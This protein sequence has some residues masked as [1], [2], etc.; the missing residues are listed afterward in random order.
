MNKTIRQRI[1]AASVLGSM[2]FAAHAFEVRSPWLSERGPLAYVFETEKEDKYSL[3]IWKAMYNKSASKAF[4]EHGTE[5]HPLTALYFGKADFPMTQIFEN[6]LVPLEMEN[7]IPALRL[8][9]L[10][11]RAQYNERGITI[12]GRFEYPVYEN[13]GRIGV[14]A[15]I[16]FRCIEIEREDFSGTPGSGDLSDIVVS[17]YTDLVVGD[18]F[19]E[20]IRLD[21]L[22]ALRA[23]TDYNSFV[24]YNG[25]TIGSSDQ[26]VS[27][28]D[29]ADQLAIRYVKNGPP[30]FKKESA[31]LN[32]A[33][34]VAINKDTKFQEGVYYTF[35]NQLANKVPQFADSFLGKSLSDIL[36]DQNIKSHLWASKLTDGTDI[37]QNTPID[38]A[39]E[40][41]ITHL[42]FIQENAYAWLRDHGVEFNSERRTGLGDID[43]DL[44][45]E[46]RFFDQLIGEVMIGL[47][48]P[49][50]GSSKYHAS[51]YHPHLG[52]GSHVE[53]RLGALLAYQPLDWMNMKLD[54]YYSFALENTEHRPA[55]FKGAQVRGL[56]P[57]ADAKVDW[58]Y[59]VGRLDFNFF[60][61]QTKSMSSMIGYELFVKQKD[62]VKFKKAKMASW[63]GQFYQFDATTPANSA[64]VDRDSALDNTVAETDTDSMGHKVRAEA[65]YRVNKYL[66]FFLGGSYVFAGK[67]VPNETDCH[68]G[69]RV[70]F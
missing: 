69:F 60:H 53:L 44:F 8:A 3:N 24:N 58:G 15:S 59:F 62:H 2:S 37:G 39:I 61:P 45:Y 64:F 14:R 20:S 16:P 28:L 12:G 56:G 40:M 42:Q 21:A 13:K 49:T 27:T 31:V 35:D 65:S 18:Q 48:L 10:H 17:D 70:N 47:R 23:S 11:P 38:D 66:E 1:V 57:E 43:L 30:R 36:R 63:L 34:F 19:S 50:G 33:T 51:P 26:D 5:T 54:M 32:T 25:V 29:I 7:Y 68:G 55:A 4:K 67:N 22:E 6:S 41:G 9:T 52:N 46:H